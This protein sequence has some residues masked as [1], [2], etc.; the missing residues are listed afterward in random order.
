VEGLIA[1]IAGASAGSISLVGFGVDSFI[2]VTSGAAVLWRMSVDA[3]EPN[4]ERREV[5]TLRIVGACF[6][7]LAVYVG[8]EA[9][10]DLV[11]RTGP[12]QSIPESFS[13]LC[14]WWS[15]HCSHAQNVESAERLA[16]PQCTPTRNRRSSAP[17]CPP[18]SSAV[19][20]ATWFGPSGGLIPSPLSSW[21]RSSPKKVSRGY[22]AIRV[23][24]K[25]PDEL[26]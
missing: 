20:S 3:D 22:V 10:S 19:F 6:V 12:E 25:A 1:V 11:T 7:A 4:R 26:P 13:R 14:R 23:A 17:I 2:E 5:R 8:F 16:A 21:C 18:F 15:C 9:I 24:T